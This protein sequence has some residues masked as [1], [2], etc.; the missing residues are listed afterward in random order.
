MTEALLDAPAASE[1]ALSAAPANRMAIA[2]LSLAGLFVSGYLALKYAGFGGPIAC[3]GSGGCT[4][5]QMSP[6]AW[7]LGVPVPLIGVVGNLGLLGVSLAGLQPGLVDR[8]WIA[9]AL[10]GMAAVAAA[11][12]AYLT[13]LEAFVI[14]AWCRWCVAAAVLSALVFLAALPELRRLRGRA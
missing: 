1:E 3:G 12:C 4:A 9:G 7:F 14:H 13:A 2:L 10:F 11:F 8:R 6:Y 5:V